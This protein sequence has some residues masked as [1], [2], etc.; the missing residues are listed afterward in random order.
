ML[1]KGEGVKG[2]GMDGEEGLRGERD[3]DEGKGEGRSHTLYII[4]AED[5][6]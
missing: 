3:G 6:R 2:K 4:K 1:R 5:A